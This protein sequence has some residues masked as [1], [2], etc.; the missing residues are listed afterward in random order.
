VHGRE[1]LRWLAMGVQAYVSRGQHQAP[2]PTT[3]SILREPEE[4]SRH[5]ERDWA[6]GIADVGS[7]AKPRLRSKA[8]ECRNLVPLMSQLCTENPQC[9][10]D[11]G[12]HLQICCTQLALFYKTMES[13]P[14]HMSSAGLRTLQS[15]MTRFLAHWKLFGGHLVYKHHCAWHLAEAASRHGNPKYYLTY[16]DEQEN[17]VMGAVAKS[18]HGGN[19]FY[20]TFLQKVLPDMA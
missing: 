15:S 4:G 9:L 14:R 17:R 3:A 20:L 10:G 2:A 12:M 16:A 13:E 11:R 18:L 6:I 7:V 19:T 1:Q 5:D 8:A